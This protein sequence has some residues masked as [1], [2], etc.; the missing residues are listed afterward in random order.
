[1]KVPRVVKAAQQKV[2][3][4]NGVKT[5]AE[6]V[7]ENRE[8]SLIAQDAKNPEQLFKEAESYIAKN[9][10]DLTINLGTIYR[11]SRSRAGYS[12]SKLE[13]RRIVTGLAGDL[14]VDVEF[15]R[16]LT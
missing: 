8:L 16:R 15:V 1:G 14:G 9:D 13:A 3:I 12:I 11:A 4:K 2:A 7:N 10:V 6:I 5:V